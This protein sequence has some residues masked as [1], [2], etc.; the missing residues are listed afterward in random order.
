MRPGNE[1]VL[2]P[3]G[4]VG[5][6]RLATAIPLGERGTAGTAVLE[7]PAPRRPWDP[8]ILF[9][10][11]LAIL[12]VFSS[13]LVARGLLRPLVQLSAFTR[14]FGSGNLE[15][16]VRIGRREPFGPLAATFDEMAERIGALMNARKSCWPTS[17]TSCAPRSPASGWRSISPRSPA[18]RRRP[19]P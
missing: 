1:P 11:L 12:T 9:P 8:R 19:H 13:L 18:R 10:G 15:A 7:H 4:P 14:E 5:G 17:P 3:L 2:R 16:R 6:D